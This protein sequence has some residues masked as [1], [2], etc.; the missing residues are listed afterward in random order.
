[1]LT[2]GDEKTSKESYQ[3][4]IMEN[5]R[6]GKPVSRCVICGEDNSVVLEDHHIFGRANSERTEL[7]CKN[8]HAKI[9]HEQNKVSPKSRSKNASY[10]EK[11]LYQLLTI[12]VLIRD[13]GNQIIKVTHEL[14]DFVKNCS[15]GLYSQS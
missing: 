1:M 3:K 15:S 12:G 8:C 11:S 14:M 7:L 10:L 2:E 5:I 4:S 9:T 6:N 13:L